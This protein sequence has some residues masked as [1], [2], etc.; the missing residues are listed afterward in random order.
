MGGSAPQPTSS[1]HRATTA[2]RQC[3]QCGQTHS[4]PCFTPSLSLSVV[5]DRRSASV[6][7]RACVYGL[8]LCV[9]WCGVCAQSPFYALSMFPYPSGALHMGHVRVYTI[10]DCIARYRRMRGDEVVHPMG[11]DAFGLP[12]EN[13]AI[14]RHIA[15]DVWTQRNIAAMKK[16]LQP[17]ALSFDWHRELTTCS[18]DYYQHTQRL[19]IDLF[20]AGLAYQKD[21]T[22]NWDPVDHTVLA[23]EQVD[24]L[25]RSWRSGAK[26]ERRQL[27]QW[28]IRLT[29]YTEQLLDGLEGLHGWTD[30][31]KAM[32]RNWIG[33][34]DGANVTFSVLPKATSNTAT[35]A[36]AHS[37]QLDVFTTR[38]DTLHGVSFICVAPEH[39]I[40]SDS[41]VPQSEW[42]AVESY[43]QR[44]SQLS[45]TER[46]ESKDGVWSG[47]WAINP[48]NGQRVKLMV[49]A[50]VLMEYGTGAVMGVPAHDARDLVFA[51]RHQLPI[52]PV[53]APSLDAADASR[54]DLPYTQHGVL[55]NSGVH[56][57]L[58]STDAAATIL[59]SLSAR[60]LA[61]PVVS[62]RLRD[63]LVSRQRYW[64]TPIPM[65]HCRSCGVLPVPVEQ[66]PVVLP[67]LSRL[68]GRGG[69]PLRSE[70][71]REW[72]EVACP[73]C[74][75]AA[76][77]DTDTL[78]TFVDSSW[79]FLRYLSPSSSAPF[80]PAA[81][82]RFMPASTYVGGIEH[83][84]L[85][86]LYA[87]FFTRFLYHRGL[88]PSPEPFAA[89]LTQGI[90][91][92]RTFK[93]PQTGQFI[94]DDRVEE[95]DGS[96][97]A[98]D[99]NGCEYAVAVVWEKMS[100][101]KHNGVEPAA[102]I[103]RYGADTV[104]LYILFKAPPEKAL[105]WDERSIAGPARWI[106]R[107]HS[108]TQQH[109]QASSHPPTSEGDG[110]TE[111]NTAA[112]ISQLQRDVS[113]AV[114]DVSRQL[115]GRLFNVAL[116]L[117][118]K[119]TN[120]M[121]AAVA[122]SPGLLATA[123]FHDSLR[124][125][126]RLIAPFAPHLASEVW[127]QLNSSPTS[128]ASYSEHSDVHQQPWP[129]IEQ[130]EAEQR[131]AGSVSVN[132]LVNGRRLCLVDMPVALLSDECA[133]QSH[134]RGLAELQ[135]ALSGRHVQRVIVKRAPD[136]GSALI[137]FVI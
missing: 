73:K 8:V 49:G 54:T 125:L 15:P 127:W 118:M 9:V 74:G 110:G 123:S 19:F 40:L 36:A 56:S 94:S 3:S 51:Q 120:T 72:R 82:A 25:G 75:G 39:P 80:D 6:Y 130:S 81:V 136:K 30:N 87:R 52:L 27:R 131:M 62:Y 17:L 20:E 58:S 103:D 55:I 5:S 65:I 95:R 115:D 83:A 45:D 133:M 112:A 99:D 107:L 89:L 106:H 91:Q 64:G 38:L 16:Q 4:A 93:H 97:Y 135:A 117:L 69:S 44:T 13:A 47:L 71:C 124:T 43:K 32:Q 86:L 53:V 92:G 12:A 77:R 116:A 21:A 26:V 78:D 134:A 34:S 63:W 66:L 42:A 88:L 10:S 102:A 67:S 70:E 7:M 128:A 23:N 18:P 79:Y 46:S 98:R 1:A 11:W 109:R 104:R 37:T 24:S 129:H 108:L 35:A 50:Y 59:S 119:L 122:A 29:A 60:S 126:A 2:E 121:V 22:V 41:N 137:N 14:E 114:R 132:I 76:E 48:I 84:I 111:P 113:E 101:S 68:A 33:K 61:C 85:H 100:K 105:D 28:F 96:F 31:V 90:V 57:G